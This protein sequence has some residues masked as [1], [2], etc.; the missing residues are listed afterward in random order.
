MDRRSFLKP[1]AAGALGG[2]FP[3]PA[4]ADEP[5]AANVPET[6]FD[7]PPGT[8]SLA[9]LPDTQ[10]MT[11]LR[12][13][14]FVR[15]T[16]WIAKHRKSHDIR[17]VTQLGDITDNNVPE[18]WA[19]AKKAADVLKS[20]GV[21]FSFLPGNHDLGP[22]GGCADRST[23]MNDFFKPEDYSN[24]AKVSYF[25]TGRMENSAHEFDS[26]QGKY[27]VL[28]LEFGPRDEVVV[29]AD[30]VIGAHPDHRVI[31]TTHVY[32]FSDD[33]RY[34]FPAKGK[35][36]TWNPNTYG[37]A[38][39]GPVNDGEALWRKLVSKHANI[40]FVLNGHVLNDGAGRLS[41][42]GASEKT[43]HQILSNYQGGVKPDRPFNG[44]GFL[45]LMRFFPDGKTVDVKTY[46]PW[47]DEWLT[48]E[49]QQFKLEV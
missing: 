44:G 30:R 41:S 15:Q 26:P 16:E 47:L 46:S 21:P 45:R 39:L 11:R 49:Q 8:W 1:V 22:N 14:M 27:L 5:H 10:T 42:P 34:D 48:D 32:L 36:Q 43:V 13:E 23:L 35:T 2:F 19:N 12:P 4:I 24:S 18:Q 25:E 3:G 20:A 9:V 7:A 33:T 29:W 28:A 40:R 17:F 31:V 38:K 37:V 6:P